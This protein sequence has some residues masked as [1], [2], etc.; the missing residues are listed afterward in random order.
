MKQRQGRFGPLA[1]MWLAAMVGG[2]CLGSSVVGGVEDGGGADSARDVSTDLAF[3]APETGDAADAGATADRAD[4]A[5]PDANPSDVPPMCTSNAQCGDN[6]F[7]QHVC[8]VTTG[9][10]VR[11][12]T[13]DDSC[14][15][16][17]YCNAGSNTCVRGCRNDDAC[18]SATDGGVADGGAVSGG[19]CNPMTRTCV[20][21]VS[22]DQCATG[23]RCVGSVC[24]T[25][26][27]DSTRCGAGQACCGGGCVDTQANA[28][29]CGACGTVCA[30]PNAAA[31]CEMGT[32]RVG[33]CTGSFRD[34]DMGAANGCETNTLT[35][36]ANCGG[37]GRVCPTP[38]NASPTCAAGACGY[39]C[40]TGF[41]DCDGD[42]ANGCEVDTRSDRGNCG[43]CMNACSPMGGT[44][45]CAMGVCTV[46]ACNE[47]F[48]DCDMNAANGC[49]TDV[50]V[51]TA[52]CGV[53]GTTCPAPAN[54]AATCAMGRCGV[55]CAAGFA[56]C[57]G[58]AANGCEVDTRTDNTHCGACGRPCVI[59]NGT[60]GCAAGM[61]AVGMCNAGFAD[62][63]GNVANGCETDTRTASANCG[64]CGNACMV[65]GGSAA[66]TNGACAVGGCAPGRSDCD[67]NPTNGCEVDTQTSAANCGACGRVCVVPNATPVCRDGRCGV[68]TCND[69]FGDCDGDPTNGCETDLR[70]ATNNCG[71]CGSVCF[72]ANGVAV[73]AAGACA[74][75]R[76]NAGFADCN[77]FYG[78]G[79]EIA[80]I[81]DVN[82]CATCGNVC[83]TPTAGTRVCLAGVCA[84]GT[85][86]AGTGDCDGNLANG[87]EVNTTTTLAH[88][89]GCGRACAAR[90]NASLFCAA[91]ACGFTCNPGFADCDGNAANGCEVDVRSN[92]GNCG[93]CGNACSTA[94]GTE[95]CVAG[96]CGIGVC[97]PGFANCD[98]L[99]PNGCEV[100]TRSNS[101]NCG[102]CGNLC[103][104]PAGGSVTCSSSACAQTCPAG[105]SNCGGICRTTGSACTSVGSGGC[106]QSGTL[107]CSGTTTVCSAAPLTT[108]A[109]SSP[110]GGA[111]GAGG[112]CAC[113][114][115]LTNC[116]GTCRALSSDP[117][118]CGGCGV[119]CSAPSGGSV[120]CSAGG[121]VQ[122]CPAGQTNCGGVCRVT[123]SSCT[124]AG[125]GGC[126]QS[127]TVVCSGT[128]TVC[129]VGPRT[130]G[131]CASPTGGSCDGAGNCVCP[132]GQSNC[133]GTCRTLSSDVASCG[134]CGNVCGSSQACV[135]G[136]CIGQGSLRF[137]LT[138]NINGDMDLHVLPPCGTE[139]FYGRLSACG[140]TQDRDDVSS[141]GPENIFWTGSYTPGRYY[142]CP[143]SY[144][145]VVAN[146]TWTL[147]V[148]RNG[149]TIATRTG[150]RGRQDGNITCNSSFPGVVALDI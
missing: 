44:G 93:R 118:N 47:G 43:R 55:V 85:C 140:G 111:C 27:T 97:N 122:A 75:D 148:V 90:A 117:S 123:G 143:E 51:S 108:G 16:G 132:A 115:G 103:T 1:L 8:D 78:D 48:G 135:S 56:D 73:C 98:T 80:T 37:C 138:W 67:M 136:V 146:A 41:A 121:C 82:N 68:G 77:R 49:E 52:N 45:A 62:C 119:V 23:Q 102:T 120:T 106:A 124:S 145:G 95:T 84:I 113:A 91:G 26:C 32:C 21:C 17:E 2:G 12:T 65:A 40:L 105:Q 35:D 127:G 126:A 30:T 141:Q 71:R 133:S 58:L 116:G 53:C 19:R 42:A 107:V 9:R 83:P 76:C 4:G 147:T 20:D 18:R 142:V 139:I 137:T 63:D 69:G 99:V 5:A 39:T 7:G 109:C 96:V 100:D 50:R 59:P 57:D 86:L 92:V 70:T 14:A 66:C 22:D 131:T 29:N 15:A 61:C 38:A 60:P 10:C 34:C 130:S 33:E 129:S 31:R 25:G 13:T 134:A 87:C 72:A 94:N 149:V 54:G 46:A 144:T 114:A 24:V 3:D 64:R 6:E 128:T 110:V 89:G 101:S 150:V 81:S 125:S 79:C 36:L 74:L 112:T 11:C 88:C 28:A 104:A